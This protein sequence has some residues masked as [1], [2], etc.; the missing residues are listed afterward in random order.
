MVTGTAMSESESDQLE[1]KQSLN[2][3]REAVQSVAAFATARGG[4]VHIGIKPDGTTVG[5]QLGG[6]SLERLAEQ[7]KTNTDPPQ[8]PSITTEG[9]EDAAV[10][11][12]KVDE[13]PV[14][15]VAAFGIAYKRWGKR[16]SG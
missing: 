11:S 16:I 10:I 13:A 4:T 12:V 5:I 1:L 7:I 8:Y 2:E 9:P 3:W 14:K 15:P 6:S